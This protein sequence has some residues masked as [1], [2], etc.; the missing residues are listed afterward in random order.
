MKNKPITKSDIVNEVKRILIL[1]NMTY[2]E[3]KQEL[4]QR[5]AVKS[6]INKSI[7]EIEIDKN[8]ITVIK[9]QSGF[10]KSATLRKLQIDARCNSLYLSIDKHDNNPIYF[11]D[12]I[13]VGLYVYLLAGNVLG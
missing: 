7:K 4:L 11:I 2:V 13:N 9:A 12:K 3:G 10:D 8:K 1:N 6:I 5:M